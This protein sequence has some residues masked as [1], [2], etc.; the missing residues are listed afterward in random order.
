VF[1]QYDQ[2]A[3]TVRRP[4]FDA[5][6]LRLRPALRG[7]AHRAMAGRASTRSKRAC[8]R[9]WRGAQ[10]RVPGG[11]PIGL[12]DCLNFG[13]PEKPEIAYELAQAIEGIARRPGARH[14]SSGECVAYNETDGLLIPPT[15]V[16]R[17]VGVVPDVRLVPARWQATSCPW[18]ARA[19][20]PRRRDRAIR[21][22]WKAAPL[23]SLCHDVGYGGTS[24]RSPRLHA[25]ADARP[26][27]AAGRAAQR[28]RVLAIAPAELD[29]PAHAACRDGRR[30]AMCGVFGVYAARDVSRLTYFGPCAAAPRAG[31]AASPSRAGLFTALAISASSAGVRRAE[32][33]R[34]AGAGGDRPWALL[35]H[36]LV[37]MVECA[38][39]VRHGGAH[40]CARTT[41][42]S[43][44]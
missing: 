26:T 6:V 28:R 19:G 42:S 25:G 13:N 31:S 44:R 15:P 39:T 5:A 10:C 3:R 35:D 24:R 33:A 2:L 17:C 40:D 4:G 38:V 27:S 16:C 9:R 29:L 43:T 37:G 21:F 30:A 12:T 41:A 20:Q 11:E 14:P 34:A 18:R 7:R 32:A 8:R 1:E 22:L 36:R 23:L